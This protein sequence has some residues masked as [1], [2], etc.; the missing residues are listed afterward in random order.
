MQTE[1]AQLNGKGFGTYQLTLRLPEQRFPLAVKVLHTE[2]AYRIYADNEL[3]GGVGTPA[4][5]VAGTVPQWKPRVYLLPRGGNSLTLTL[6]VANFHHARGGIGYGIELGTPEAIL[7]TR[8]RALTFGILLIGALL[9]L[10]VYHMIAFV[11][12]RGDTTAFY[13]ALFCFVLAI[14]TATT[15]E[16]PMQLVYADMP[17]W[18]HSRLVYLS[19][20]L[21]VPLFSVY[22]HALFVDEFP[23]WALLSI[24][25]VTSIFCAIVIF[26][27]TD[28]FSQTIQFYYALTLL[29]GIL[30]IAVMARAAW[31]KKPSASVLIVGSL[32][33][34]AGYV[35]DV[36]YNKNIINTGLYSPYATLIFLI[37][38]AYAIS[39][40]NAS[41]YQNIEDLSLEL[42][43]LNEGLEAKIMQRTHELTRARVEAERL[44]KVKSEFLA[45]MSHE[46]RTPMNGVIG[47]LHLL[48]TTQLTS[49]Q[50]NYI[51]VM[52]ASASMLTTV[53]NDVLDLSQIESGRLAIKESSFSLKSAI[54]NVIRIVTP[55]AA[56]KNLAVQSGFDA[57]VHDVIATDETRLQQI[58][59]NL[60][61]NAVKFTNSGIVGINVVAREQADSRIELKITVS[62]TGVGIK[63]T[64]IGKLFHPFSQVDSSLS[65]SHQGTG[66]GLA[67]S[68]K[69]AELLGGSLSVE[70]SPGIGSQFTLTLLVRPGETNRP[71]SDQNAPQ[72]E[73]PPKTNSRFHELKILVAEDNPVNLLLM[74]KILERLG[75]QADYAEN[76][77]IACNL[78]A[79][80]DYDILL[81]DIAMPVMNGIEC[82]AT[83]RERGARQ[84]VIVAVTADAMQETKEKLLRGDFDDYLTKPVTPDVI[85]DCLARWQNGRASTRDSK[86]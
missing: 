61:N 86:V 39:A 33:L 69:L 26:T 59:L 27:P 19:F 47:S 51:D 45:N 44:A 32:V 57:L 40:R 23:R 78:T 34:L 53:I 5:S 9:V 56:A 58:L 66:L 15:G 36:L 49:E 29:I 14:R 43:T 20:Y 38:Q 54:A 22:I 76:G 79:S 12:R 3:L 85:S 64:D 8:E 63:A 55:A 80:K 70:S 11:L 67:I 60:L 10:C 24:A 35:N 21:A 74:E 31:R 2:T 68:R 42:K 82:A 4:E 37:F 30:Y 71:I 18:L 81:I 72:G 46:I 62:D 13:F 1:L 77:L 25:V 6:H 7:H 50:R 28:V 41:A 83:V 17:Y 16:D 84:P 52:D 48:R 65:R 75:I 73:V